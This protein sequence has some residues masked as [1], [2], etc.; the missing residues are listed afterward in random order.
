[1]A[2]RALGWGGR[3]LVVGFASGGAAPKAAIPRL[4]LNLALLNERRVPQPVTSPACRLAGAAAHYPRLL[5][6]WVLGLTPPQRLTPPRAWLR[7]ALGT[8]R[9]AAQGGVQAAAR[10]TAKVADADAPTY[11]TRCLVSSGGR[12][13][14]ASETPTAPTLRRCSA[15]SHGASCAR[16]AAACIGSMSGGR[17]STTSCNTVRWARC[18]SILARRRRGCERDAHEAVKSRRARQNIDRRTDNNTFLVNGTIKL[19]LLYLFGS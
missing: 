6:S 10:R 15:S 12:G 1:M 9:R 13:R 17:P 19:T 3:F 14:R 2:F 5:E 11:A 8:R 16:R 7:C 18:A 4:P